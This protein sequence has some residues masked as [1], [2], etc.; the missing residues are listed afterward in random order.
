MD[1]SLAPPRCMLHWKAQV[2]TDIRGLDLSMAAVPTQVQDKDQWRTA[3][4]R[5]LPVGEE[6]ELDGRTCPQ[7]DLVF[8][9]FKARDRHQ[10]TSEACPRPTYYARR[11]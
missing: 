4:S 6:E 1:H 8:A 10:R 5:A 9:S 2:R 3:I 7:C 11:Q